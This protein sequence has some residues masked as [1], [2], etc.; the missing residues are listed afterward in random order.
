[1]LWGDSACVMLRV[2]PPGAIEVHSISHL[3][4]PWGW[5]E[6]MDLQ[7]WLLS[8]ITE[9]SL[10]LARGRATGWRY[11][12]RA[13]FAARAFLRRYRFTIILIFAAIL[14]AGTWL[15]SI[16][17]QWRIADAFN[18]SDRLG[19]LRTFL[20]TLGA[21]LVG[22]TA[23]GFSFV[24]FAMQVNVERMPH[25]LF[26]RLSRD[27]RLMWSFALTFVLA[28][29]VCI[30]GL[31]PSS[32]YASFAVVGTAA[33][34][35]LIVV[36]LMYSYGRALNLI[37]PAYQLSLVA[38]ETQRS[39]TAWGRR[40][41]RARP[42]LQSND[43][44]TNDI[45]NDMPLLTYFRANPDWSASAFQGVRYAM[46]FASRYATR[47][48]YEVT[49]AALQTVL[50]VNALYI[51]AKGKTFFTDNL[52]F[53]HPM[54][55]DS[56][57]NETLESL[58]QAVASAVSTEDERYLEQL[59]RAFE[60]LAALYACIDY[61]RPM[62]TPKHALLAAGYLSGAVETVMPKGKID[63]VMEGVRS[64]GRTAEVLL[65]A[66]QAPIN[67]VSATE[68]I[69]PLAA[70]C[71]LGEKT[72]P[73]TM[74][75]VEQLAKLTF[76]ILRTD[77]RDARY[78]QQRINDNILLIA[79]M[80]LSVS[81]PMNSTHSSC[82]G[83]YYSTTRHDS[84]HMWFVDLSN[85]ILNADA[86]NKDAKNVIRNLIGWT[87]EIWRVQRDLFK[88]SIEKRSQFTFDLIHWVTQIAKCLLAV[89]NAP[90]C[91]ERSKKALID[92]ALKLVGV[93]TRWSADNNALEFCE[94]WGLSGQ[95]FEIA[96]EAH[97]RDVPDVM[98]SARGALLD[99]GFREISEP[100]VLG[101][102]EHTL[103]GC[104]ALSLATHD[105]DML[106][107]Q[108]AGRLQ[109]VQNPDQGFL[110][111]VARRLRK[112]GGTLQVNQFELS[113]I[114][115]VLQSTNPDEAETLLNDIANILSPNTVGEWECTNW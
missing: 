80:L 103:E 47:G 108:V 63:V 61:A 72:R 55:S 77:S 96:W 100:T 104:A 67:T 11:F 43:A 42:L 1:M 20:I 40:A 13:S 92:N 17:L 76:A 30:A 41:R 114:K 16:H 50:A 8:S 71:S 95:I 56:F 23:I 33:S 6:L 94:R 66:S 115:Q 90:A 78:A 85:G 83:S 68:K 88:L 58:R 69:G 25:G 10:K 70:A 9:L 14:T 52:L 101:I 3:S 15:W 5:F 29:W 64:M 59:L 31:I 19:D 99:L 51:R 98:T 38:A 45:P 35:V 34:C 37:N 62:A 49:A 97:I 24:M 91:D 112:I 111:T 75:A 53:A 27:P 65:R 12:Y 105:A 36:L 73:I 22:A 4:I 54:S 46:A 93:L 74:V 79:N 60:A 84:F 113:A 87:D 2:F 57:I 106:K 44:E 39:L 32:N 81:D 18:G 86:D 89:C 82:L 21:A 110:D 7:K 28:I 102:L 107:A 26:R 48:D 109:Q